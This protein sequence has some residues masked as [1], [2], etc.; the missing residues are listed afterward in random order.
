[1]RE[2]GSF[3]DS[4]ASRFRLVGYS[5]YQAML[6]EG[7]PD[8]EAVALSFDDGFLGVHDHA[9]PVL[10]E[11]GLDAVAF[12]NPPFI[13]NPPDRI[14]HFLE[15]E[16]AFRLTACDRLSVSFWDAAF[17]LTEIRS[18]I[19]AM[20]RVKK[21]LKTR[22]E[23]E[24]AAC[25][26]EVLGALGVPRDEILRHAASAAKYR[27]M[28]AGQI[29]ALRDLGW[30]IGSH[31]MSHRTLSMLPEDALAAEIGDAARALEAEF[32]WT[33]LP[34][35]YPYGAEIHVGTRPP[36]VCAAAGHPLAFTTIPGP[37][38]AAAAPHLL[39]RIDYKVFL[40]DQD[41]ALAA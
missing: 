21:L 37:S 14:F 35:A 15:L 28:E 16:I 9:A 40:R 17:D 3:L 36:Q 38:D 32:G 41:L 31:T 20:K 10:A 12:V 29:R 5:D 24:R 33:G 22:P 27:T 34:F 8:P 2:F 19:A 23:A 4:V 30:T 26:A 18:R 11:R 39:P 13:G 6:L 1:M 25:H 7:R